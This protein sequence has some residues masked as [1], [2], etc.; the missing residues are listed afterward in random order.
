MKLRI[1]RRNCLSL[2]RNCARRGAERGRAKL[3]G[4]AGVAL[5]ARSH[6]VRRRLRVAL[7]VEERAGG[8]RT[9]PRLV[10]AGAKGQNVSA[11]TGLNEDEGQTHFQLTNSKQFEAYRQASR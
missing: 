7:G 8:G 11:D 4:T 10:I 6:L 5:K 9:E 2:R 3:G 1:L